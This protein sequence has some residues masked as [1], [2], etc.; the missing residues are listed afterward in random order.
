MISAP[1]ER[2][3]YFR[4]LLKE[5]M[6]GHDVRE[7]QELLREFGFLTDPVDGYYGPITVE[8][9]M[10]FQRTYALPVDGIAGPL[11]LKT[12][13][14]KELPT[15]QRIHVV[16]EGEDIFRLAEREDI[17]AEGLMRENGIKRPRRLYSG[18]E[19]VIKEREVYLHLPEVNR[20]EKE[21]I[22]SGAGLILP[23]VKLSPDGY[24]DNEFE[25]KE[26]F[27]KM[28]LRIDIEGEELYSQISKTKWRKDTA[29]KLSK[30]YRR[31][32][33]L[34]LHLGELSTKSILDLVRFIQ[35]LSVAMKEKREELIVSL[36]PL[37]KDSLCVRKGSHLQNGLYSIGRYAHKVMLPIYKKVLV[38]SPGP[39]APYNH[40][41]FV[42][43]RMSTLIPPWKIII[44]MPPLA[45]N[46]VKKKGEL[47]L[48]PLTFKETF[49]LIYESG[50]RVL[51]DSSNR[52]PYIKYRSQRVY[53]EIWFENTWSI[54]HKLDLVGKYN[55][56]GVAL[57]EFGTESF[58]FWDAIKDRFKC[59]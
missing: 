25:S 3:I 9:V 48:K 12:I 59:K 11:T 36:P 13:R 55:L 30:A 31:F 50:C 38:D 1:A 49:N 20:R 4:R 10:E 28:Y 35:V 40:A 54:G 2:K 51:L 27:S 19:L 43:K 17:T 5:N 39:I 23:K 46:W 58:E 33:G 8:S 16:K 41:R 7:L 18:E 52:S 22:P 6:Y 56:R 44:V 32:A 26:D 15:L 42:M 34:D 37:D 14:K 24:I 57:E 45:Y 47:Y 21:K 29:V 53:N